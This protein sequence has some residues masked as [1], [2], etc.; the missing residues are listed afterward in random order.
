MSSKKKLRIKGNI[1]D[2]LSK[3]NLSSKVK[4]NDM[5]FGEAKKDIFVNSSAFILPSYSYT[6]S[7]NDSHIQSISAMKS[8]NSSIFIS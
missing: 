6:I 4:I 1:E 7:S 3:H 2:V 5:T 8:S